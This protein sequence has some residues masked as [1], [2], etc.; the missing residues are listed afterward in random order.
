M[1]VWGHCAAVWWFLADQQPLDMQTVAAH[2]SSAGASAYATPP[3]EPFDG[4]D[5][6][7]A[8]Q[9]GMTIAPVSAAGTCFAGRQSRWLVCW[10]MDLCQSIATFRMSC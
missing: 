8:L 6:T 5:T 10:I 9:V 2:V 3:D 4:G 1:R 7:R